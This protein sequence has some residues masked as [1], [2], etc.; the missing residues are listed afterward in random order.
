MECSD[1]EDAE[2]EK[3]FR[4]AGAGAVD[5]GR[6]DGW[7][8]SGFSRASPSWAGMKLRKASIPNVLPPSI[9]KELS[10][11]GCVAEHVVRQGRGVEILMGQSL[12]RSGSLT[13]GATGERRIGTQKVD[14]ASQVLM[15]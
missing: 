1:D 4:L 7:C 2:E 15:G 14:G 8:S 6:T 3:F 12:R 13:A 9:R 5:W 10:S 11:D